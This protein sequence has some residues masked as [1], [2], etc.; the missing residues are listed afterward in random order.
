MDKLLW[1]LQYLFDRKGEITTLIGLTIIWLATI[2][3]DLSW[4]EPFLVR[5]LEVACGVYLVLHKQHP[6]PPK[7]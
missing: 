1:G 6:A 7:E 3:V 4:L 2:G 5:S